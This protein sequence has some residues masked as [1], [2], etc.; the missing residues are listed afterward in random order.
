MIDE[1]KA[2]TVPSGNINKVVNKLFKYFAISRYIGFSQI[3]LCNVL[4]KTQLVGFITMS[5]QSNHSILKTIPICKLI[6]EHAKQLVPASKML[7]ILI[8]FI[9]STYNQNP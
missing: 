1:S 9:F 4:S 5:I 7:D 2:N 3:A 6:K 8:A